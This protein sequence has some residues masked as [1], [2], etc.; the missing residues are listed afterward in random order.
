MGRTDGKKR[1][2]LVLDDDPDFSEQIREILLPLGRV[3][4]YSR[5]AAFLKA[6][7]E[8]TPNLVVIDLNLGSDRENGLDVIKQIKKLHGS[9]LISILMPSGVTDSEAIEVAF[10]SGIDDIET[11]IALALQQHSLG[12]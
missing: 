3:Q 9:H 7:R 1:L 11:V 10:Q 5:A 2:V 6:V 4:T 12:A 8:K